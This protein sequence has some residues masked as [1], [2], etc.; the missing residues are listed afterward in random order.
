V[1]SIELAKAKGGRLSVQDL[2]ASGHSADTARQT[3][4]ALN[5]KGLAQED[6]ANTATNDR[7]IIVT[8]Q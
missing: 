5:S 2:V 8:T 3:L 1:E 4:D 7:A 6:P